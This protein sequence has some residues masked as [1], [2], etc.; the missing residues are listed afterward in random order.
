MT[1]PKFNAHA[2]LAFI[3]HRTAR[4]LRVDLGEAIR[5]AGV[6]LSPEHWFILN[7][8]WHQNGCAQATLVMDGLEDRANLSRQLAM[9][10]HAGL[11]KRVPDARD[12]RRQLVFLTAKGVKVHDAVAALAQQQEERV[13]AG[14][15]D[16]PLNAA[17]KVLAHMEANLSPRQDMDPA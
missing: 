3:I 5:A 13:L 4:R 1:H 2:S 8:L 16:T 11:V 14:M 7:R 6:D 17:L 15:G 12:K 9:L 10:Q